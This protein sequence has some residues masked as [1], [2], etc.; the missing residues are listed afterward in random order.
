[1]SL[2]LLPRL[3]GLALLC[4][5]G[6]ATSGL[7]PVTAR[8]R[9]AA[10]SAAAH[11]LVERARA[12][13]RLALAASL[14]EPHPDEAL[15]ILTEL[16]DARCRACLR[17]VTDFVGG[18]GGSTDDPNVR[19]K[20]EALANDAH[21]RPTRVTRAADAVWTAFQ[22]GEWKLLA[23]YVGDQTH[24]ITIVTDTDPTQVS[25]IELSPARMR[26]WFERQRPATT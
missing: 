13:E 2:W 16:R 26:P 11:Q 4:A 14:L 19:R 10:T 5:A 18:A 3:V 12:A 23:P 22:R 24:I 9:S 15:A 6:A 7:P 17:A 8:P 1:M 21:G 20:L 25:T